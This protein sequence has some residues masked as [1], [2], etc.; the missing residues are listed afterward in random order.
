MVQPF[1]LNNPLLDGQGSWGSPSGDG[2]AASR[3]TEVRLSRY[4]QEML[5]DLYKNTVNWTTSTLGD[6]KEPVTLPVKYPNLL[7]NGA[8]GIGQGYN[9]FVPTHNFNEVADITIDLI[10]NPELDQEE[11]I[12]KLAPDFP[13]GGIVINGEEMKDVY[14]KGFGVCKVRGEVI[15]DDKNNQLIIKSFPHVRT[16]LNSIKDAISD[17]L[18]DGYFNGISDIKDLTKKGDINLIIKAKRGYSLDKLEQELYK[19]TPLQSTLSLSLMCTEDDKSFRHYSIKEIL[20]KWI[21]Y[22]KVTIKR[23]LNFDMAAINKRL[24]IIEALLKAL[25]DIDKVISIIKQSENKQDSI[26]NLMAEPLFEFNTLQARYI[27]DLPLSQLSKIGKV[28]LQEEEEELN[29]KLSKL[30]ELFTSDKK[31]SKKIIKELE[32]GKKKFG[33]ERKTKVTNIDENNVEVVDKDYMLFLTKQGFIKKLDLELNTQ[34]SNTKGRKCGK[35]R[36]NDVI[37]TVLN[38]HNKDTI[39]FFTNKGNCYGLKA[40]DIE[41]VGLNTLGLTLNSLLTFKEDEYVVNMIN[42]TDDQ[43]SDENKYLVFATHNGL[44]KK[45]KLTQYQKVNKNA[46]IAIKLQDGDYVKDIIITEDSDDVLLA[47]NMGKYSR[48]SVSELSASLRMTMGVICMGG[49]QANE[50]VVSMTSI[51]E[52]SYIV[53]IDKEGLGKKILNDDIPVLTRTN[54]GRL[55]TKT[56]TQVVSVSEAKEDS[57]ITIITKEKMLKIKVADIKEGI[58]TSKGKACVNLSSGDEVLDMIIE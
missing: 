11:I 17:K 58:R 4:G 38:I 37:N 48:Y 35:L 22:R 45:T 21:D 1:Y 56:N 10:N 20:T 13:L 5:E 18:K 24:H 55:L 12:K 26:N 32:D 16:N 52:D 29:K 41:E 2:A 3:Y 49:I 25:R 9:S 53:V 44:I 36:N 43:F 14:R 34:A 6:D 42:V 51:K 8:Y 28:S 54:K 31:L 30:R 33:R 19:L 50:Y 15:K 57:N 46:L 47:T 27:V 23:S 40:Y 7:I 39:V